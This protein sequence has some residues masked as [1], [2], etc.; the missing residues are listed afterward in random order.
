MKKN[1]MSGFLLY[2]DLE[3]QLNMLS[4]E[5]RGMLISAAF[6]YAKRGEENEELPLAVRIVFST[7]KGHIDRNREKYE[8][9][10][11]RN[12]ENGKLGGRPPK[13]IY[14]S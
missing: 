6:A 14:G 7:I 11:K 12:S 5:E 9:I 1:S 10:C 13:Y 4:L 3:D 8:N 2:Y